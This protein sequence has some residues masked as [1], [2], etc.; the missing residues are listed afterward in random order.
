MAAL[1]C[2]N[3]I[4][5]KPSSDTPLCAVRLVE[6][7]EQAGVPKGVLNL[8]T[9][10]GGAV[11][12]SIVKHPDV[13]AVS[14][15]GHKDTGKRIL[16][17]AAPQVKRVGLELGSKNAIIVMPDADLKL[18]VDG[19]LWGGYGTTGQR[20]TAASRVIV[21]EDVKAALEKALLERVRKLRVGSGLVAATDMGPMV[22]E[23]AVRKTHEYCQAGEREGAKLLHGG[24][25]MPELPGFFHQPTLFTDVTKDMRIA[26]EEIFGPVV[27]LMPASSFDEV[28]DICNSVDYGLVNSVYTRDITAAFKVIERVETGITYVNASTI[29]AEVHLPF[30]GVKQSGNGAREGGIEGI[31][32]FSETKAVYIDYSG[33]LQKAQIETAEYKD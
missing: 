7:C 13:R 22:N 16:E 3:T 4:V 29:G 31:N 30:G 26:R 11:G 33:R 28:I 5:W 23:A 24:K 19:I 27:G 10:P 21:H 1:I 9:G 32:E 15:T 18:A 14:F 2:G 20:C 12:E 17:L 6:A 25:P 8:V